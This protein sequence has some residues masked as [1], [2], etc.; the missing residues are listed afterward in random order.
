M[1]IALMLNSVIFFSVMYGVNPHLRI[2][3]T[4]GIYLCFILTWIG[5]AMI[6]SGLYIYF[7]FLFSGKQY[8]W[9]VLLLM[10]ITFVVGF[11]IS[12]MGGNLLAYIIRMSQEWGILSPMMWTSLI[13]GMLSLAISSKLTNQKLQS[14]DLV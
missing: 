8:L 9:L 4:I 3:M 7:E 6:I 14:R 5:Y 13:G 10:S 1:F 2:E 12:I 11:M